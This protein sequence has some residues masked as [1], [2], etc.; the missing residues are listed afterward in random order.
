MVKI[1]M[2]KAKEDNFYL[3]VKALIATQIKREEL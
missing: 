1:T 2:M 3:G